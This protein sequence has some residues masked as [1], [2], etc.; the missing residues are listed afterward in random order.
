MMSLTYASFSLLRR[1]APV[2]VLGRS[3][4]V[5]AVQWRVSGDLRRSWTSVDRVSGG[6]RHQSPSSSLRSSPEDID[7]VD[8]HV[9]A[10]D[11]RDTSR[12]S[13]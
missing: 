4:G 13:R 5:G 7:S 6:V 1:Y 3:I 10:V 9:V 12:P 2:E 11:E 8:H